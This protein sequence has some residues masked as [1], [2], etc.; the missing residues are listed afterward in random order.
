MQILPGMHHF[1][2]LPPV[3]IVLGVAGIIPFA[4]LGIGAVGASP[5][6]SLA[7]TRALVGYGAVILAFLGGVHWGFAL[8]EEHGAPG[9]RARLVLGV[10]PSL[11]GWIAILCGIVA[12]PVLGLAILIAAFIATVIVESRAQRADL[13]PSGYMAMRWALSVAVVALLTTVL[14]LRL[15]GAH[16]LL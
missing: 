9:E 1:R 13:L 4:L 2:S 12:R 7:A 11:V 6:S 3:A 5:A 14:V 10:V 15:A 8:G 16:V